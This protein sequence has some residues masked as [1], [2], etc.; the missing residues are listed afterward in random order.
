MKKK[1]TDE[2]I[3]RVNAVNIIDY[4][5]Y[6]GLNLKHSNRRVKVNGWNGLDVT[7]DGRKWKDFTSGQ[8]G[9]VI[10]FVMWLNNMGWKDA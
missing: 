1:Y 3:D 8:G 7:P 5:A 6:C 10:Q 2:Q 9:G 4:M